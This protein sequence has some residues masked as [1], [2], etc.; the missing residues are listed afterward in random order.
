MLKCAGKR[1]CVFIWLHAWTGGC[2]SLA[3][4]VHMHASVHEYMYRMS[5]VCVCVCVPEN[6]P[7]KC[8]WCRVCLQGWTL[9]SPCT[10]D[11]QIYS[12]QETAQRSQR[13]KAAVFN[14]SRLWCTINYFKIHVLIFQPLILSVWSYWYH[15]YHYCYKYKRFSL[16]N[17]I[18]QPNI[19]LVCYSHRT[20][21]VGVLTRAGR[22]ALLGVYFG[23]PA[24]NYT[25]HL[26]LCDDTFLSEPG[27][28]QRR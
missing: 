23:V 14:R 3:M 4:C 26:R 19:T 28:P 15:V 10:D 21:R 1:V 16:H 9:P 12:L 13:S 8:I 11:P 17:H 25:L 20:E 18:P 6:S 24:V 27:H 2:A 7:Y 5:G 22:A